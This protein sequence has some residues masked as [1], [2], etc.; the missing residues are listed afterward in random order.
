MLQL[1]FLEADEPLTKTFS[2]QNGEYEVTPYPFA[3]HVTSHRVQVDDLEDMYNTLVMQSAEGRCLLKGRLANQLQNQSRKGQT[4]PNEPTQFLVLDLDFHDGWQSVEQFVDEMDPSFAGVSFIFQHSA[5]AGIKGPAGLRGHVFIL[6]THP[7]APLHLK[8]WLKIRNFQN[9][10]LNAQLTLANNHITLRWPLDIT[11]CQNDKLIYITPP[12][13]EGFDDPLKGQ[14]FVLY[15][16]AKHEVEPPKFEPA[17]VALLQ[18]WEKDKVNDL[19]QAMGLPR[20]QPKYKQSGELEIL[21]NPSPSVVTGYKSSRGFTYLNLNGGDSWAYYF[22][23]ENPSILYNFKGEPP[24]LLKDIAPEFHAQYQQVLGE[25][26]RQ[27]IVDQLGTDDFETLVFRDIV[28]DTY[29]NGYYFPAQDRVQIHKAATVQRLQHFKMQHNEEPPEF[30]E[31]WT[32][33]FDPTRLEFFDPVR[34]WINNY[35]PS[36]FLRDQTL[37]GSEIPPMIDRVLNSI[38]GG[39][40]EAKWHFINWLAHIYQTRKKSGTAWIFH[41]VEGTGKGLLF[42]KVLRPLFG[43]DHTAS[44]GNKGIEDSFN[45]NIE[46]ANIVFI[47]ELEMDSV[48]SAAQ[49]MATLKNYVTEDHTMIRAMHKSGRQIKTYWNFIIATNKQTPVYLSPTDRR[50]NVCP[51]QEKKLIMTTAEIDTI[52]DE[53]PQFAGFLRTYKVDVK[54]TREVLDNDAR[55]ALVQSS[56]TTIERFFTA[57]R[58]GQINYF[59]SFI[60]SQNPMDNTFFYTAYEQLLERWCRHAMAEAFCNV[61]RDELQTAYTYIMGRPIAAAKFQRMCAMHRIPSETVEVNNRFVAGYSVMWGGEKTAMTKFLNSRAD[62]STLKAV[63]VGEF[64]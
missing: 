19:R 51:P 16:R 2:F 32:V 28:T 48:K 63:K 24:V 26:K 64:R 41:G 10:K 55:E 3:Y 43:K 52:D 33:T 1:D 11:T 39:D 22:P 46:R 12:T 34:K 20:R 49:F 42:S 58:K 53:L 45:D 14:R 61:P 60:N 35:S 5:S 36:K 8:T 50:F 40:L 13:C 17:H 44:T 18:Q 56:Q 57:A 6:L 31:D 59:L 37:E 15:K 62:G 27:E 47:D 25:L 4:I 30:I 21:I 7:V 29:Y 38:T 9:P 54:Q 23:I